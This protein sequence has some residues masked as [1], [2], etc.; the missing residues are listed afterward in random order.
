M[1]RDATTARREVG[2]PAPPVCSVV[3]SSVR[4]AL[5]VLL[6]DDSEDDAFLVVRELERAG[7]EAVWQRVE[8]AAALAEAV[9]REPWQLVLCDYVMPQFG[10]L[11]ALRLLRHV[12]PDLPVIIVSG[13]IGEEVAVAAM[14]E[15]A[16]DYVKKGHLGRLVPAI[17]RELR[18][19]ANR[20]TR[21]QAE[22][23][24]QRAE[25]EKTVLLEVANAIGGT[26]DLHQLLDRVQ[27]RTAELLPCERVITCYRDAPGECFRII[28]QYGSPSTAA[29]IEFP[30][31]APIVER[32]T[33]HGTVVINDVGR[34]PWLPAELLVQCQLA[35]PLTVRGQT[36]GAFIA[37][38]S[39]AGRPFE[40]R[41]VQLFEAIS[42]QVA[43]AVGAA[44]SYRMQEEE[45]Q[46]TAAL[47]RIGH[48][49]IALLD[50][51]A[52]LDRLCRLSAE[53]LAC[54]ATVT[55][56]WQAEEGAYCPIAGYGFPPEPWQVLRA[57]KLPRELFG[58]ALAQLE[59]ID[60]L[61]VI[62]TQSPNAALRALAE[63]LEVSTAVCVALR[64]GAQLIGLHVA[65]YRDV[66]RRM[67]AQQERIARGIGQLASLALENARLVEEL[68]SAS[69][70]KSEFV[71]NVSHELR[72][73]LNIIT[74]YGD[75]LLDGTFGALAAEQLDA[76]RRIGD[77][78]RGLV[79]L[80]EAVLDVSRVDA[81]TVPLQVR[82]VSLAE[83]LADVATELLQQRARPAVAFA[84]EVPAHLPLVR[85]DAQKL[86]LALKNVID[87][88]FKFTR[89]GQ[90]TV[91]ARAC[92]GGVEIVVSDTGIGIAPAAVPIIFEP[93]RQVDGSTTRAYG[94]LGLGLY[95]TRRLLDALGGTIDVRSRVGHGSV[96]RIWVPQ[97]K[98]PDRI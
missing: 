27:R 95:I 59:R 58:G 32:L 62:L 20:R 8:T 54:D 92:D 52:I 28:A 26:L 53:L 39:T 72:T 41:E 15:G 38:R 66:G 75:L 83:L 23:E 24:R 61:P 1:L 63:R 36:T 64:R 55:L 2:F 67:T 6:V 34:Q 40:P 16:Q 9:A 50:R 85:T 31:G 17:E 3:E 60:A 88:A 90:V 71:A 14:K 74:G 33:T 45:A 69:R 5:R 4:G 44:E 68:A 18:D 21:R 78:A 98:A 57:L 37:A 77:S 11:A 84:C 70:L 43:V 49:M 42:R 25:D 93:F 19:A 81:G 87:N 79:T 94:G 30:A 13:E 47:A 80:I 65:C 29:P 22:V 97:L 76:V 48:E 51:P 73:P 89:E 10:G 7:Y 91:A 82:E 46:T 86:A 12:A 96:F 35:A 56:L